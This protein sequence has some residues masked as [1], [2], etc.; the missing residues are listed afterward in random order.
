MITII[1]AHPRKESFNHAI[2]ERVIDTCKKT[3]QEYQVIDLYKEKFDPVMHENEL[4]TAGK[5]YRNISKQTKKYQD[6]VSKSKKLIFIYPTWWNTMPA[7]MKGFI[8]KVF[9]GHFAFKYKQLPIINFGMPVG[10]LKEKKALVITTTGAPA[11]LASLALGNRMLTIMKR[12]ILGF[13][14]IK[15][16]S[17]QIGKASGSNPKLPQE[18]R[19]V[20]W[21]T[22]SFIEN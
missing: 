11:Y 18:L 15:A 19:R 22:L 5:E 3:N 16:T 1:Y 4:Y 8:D 21:K 12:D 9:T 14:G 2:L 10:L 20:A 7:I 17:L 13:C 6:M